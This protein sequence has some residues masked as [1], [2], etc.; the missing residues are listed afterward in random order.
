MWNIN[1][2]YYNKHINNK[3]LIVHKQVFIHDNK[4]NYGKQVYYVR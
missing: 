3:W 4:N 1:N 2:K